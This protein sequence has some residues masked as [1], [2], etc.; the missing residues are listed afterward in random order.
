MNATDV[1]QFSLDVPKS[2]SAAE[3]PILGT[4]KLRS[5][6]F[7][8]IATGQRSSP[9]GD[10]PDGYLSYSPD[11]RMYAIGVAEDRP[12]PLDLVPADEEKARLQASMFA[13][14][15]TYMADGETVIHHIDISWNQSWTGTDLVR[16]YKLDSSTLTITTAPARSAFDGEEGVFILVWE[17]VQ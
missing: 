16:F 13:Y 3:N 17:K 12:K 9:F 15:G 10:H 8:A 2:T 7:E 4:W 14:A 5:L 1:T 11:G 6:V